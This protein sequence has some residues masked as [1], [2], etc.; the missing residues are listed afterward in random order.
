MAAAVGVD[1]TPD[2]ESDRPQDDPVRHNDGD[3]EWNRTDWI[4]KEVSIALLW[5]A[6]KA[7]QR[8]HL[9]LRVEASVML[10]TPSPTIWLST[11]P[12][13]LFSPDKPKTAVVTRVD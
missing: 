3:I 10:R 4:G 11:D 1:E 5:G 6:H 7:T 8:R 13:H 2:W 12:P 9:G